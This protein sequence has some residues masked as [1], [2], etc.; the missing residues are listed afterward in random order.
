MVRGG[1]PAPEEGV[2]QG[3]KTARRVLSGL[4]TLSRTAP[5]SSACSNSQVSSADTVHHPLPR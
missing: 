3:Q 5:G 4:G 1:R 2:Q